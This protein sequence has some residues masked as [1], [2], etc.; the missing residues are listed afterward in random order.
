MGNVIAA[1]QGQAPARQASIKAGLPVSTAAITLNKMC[2]SGLQAV[3][4]AR[5]EIAVGEA[6]VVVAGGMESM[7]GAPY[8][9]PKGRGGFRMG[10]GQVLDSM[11][12]DGLWDPY[13]QVHMGNCGDLVAEKYG[14]TREQQDAFASESYR[15]AQA[16]QKEGRLKEEIVPVSVPQRRGEPIVV[17]TDEEPSRVKL[18]KVSSLP[19]AFSKSGTVTAA[20]AST[21]NDGAAALLVASRQVAEARGYP[22]PGAHRGRRHLRPGAQVVHHRTGGLPCAGSTRRPAL[23]PPT[24]IS[25]RSTRPSRA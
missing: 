22:D 23:S 7:T 4:S 25:T 15:R 5:R 3:M 13:D 24:G 12:H 2:G 16:A 6:S 17:D 18:D 9:L 14:F 1:G 10:H 11:I 8:L 19:P 21:I 20:N